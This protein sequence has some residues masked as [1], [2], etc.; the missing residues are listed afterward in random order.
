MA[1]PRSRNLSSL[2]SESG[3]KMTKRNAARQRVRQLLTEQLEPRALLAAGPLLI[4]IQPNNSDLLRAGDVRDVA[5]K[6]LVFRFDDIQRIDPATLAGIRLTSAG[7]DGTFGLLTAESDFGSIGRVSIELTSLVPQQSL[8]LNVT[9]AVL[10]QGAA[11][12]ISVAGNTVSITL[13]TRETSRTTATGLVQAIATSSALAGRMTA[14]IK[15]GLGTVTL[16]HADPTVYS[17]VRVNQTHDQIVQ[18]GAALVGQAPNENEVTLRF[19]E[20]LRDDMYRIEIFGFDDPSIG[21]VGLRNLGDTPSAIGQFYRPSGGS[22]RKDTIDFRLDLGPQVT[23]VVPQP[24]V[25]SGATLQQQRDTIVVYFDSDKMLVENTAAGNPTGR[26]VEHPDFYQ[27]IYTK[28]TVRNTDDLYFKP[29]S[30]TYNALINAVTLKFASDLND[31]PGASS[32][33]AAFRLRIGTRETQPITPTQRTESNV[34]GTFDTALNLATIGSATQSQTSLIVSSAIDPVAF[35]LDLPGASDDPGHRRL[36]QG[37][38]NSM[39]DH[40]NPNFGADSVAGVTTIFYHF[41]S[42]ISNNSGTYFS[43]ITDQQRQRTREVLSLWSSYVGVQF[44]E[45]TNQGL[46]IATGDTAM[47]N[48]IGPFQTFDADLRNEA[49]GLIEAIPYRV[50]LDPTYV[51]PV[52]AMS[53]QIQWNDLYGESFSRAIAAAVGNVLGLTRASDLS[54]SELMRFDPDFFL[55]DDPL[56]DDNDAQL[57]ANDQRFESV[58]PGNQDILHGQFLHRPD[59][60]DVDLYRFEVNFTNP[61]QVGLFAAETYAQRRINSSELDTTI[62]LYREVRAQA[63]TNFNV[64]GLSVEFT[65]KRPGSQGNQFQIAFTQSELGVGVLPIV[66]VFPNAISIALNSTPGSETTVQQMLNAIAASSGANGLVQ[67]RLVEG[68]VTAKIGAN[69]LSQNPVRLR[70]GRFELVAQNND[71]FSRDS[72]MEQSLGTGVY[73]IGV[74]ASGNEDYN[75]SIDGSGFGG[76]TQGAYDL[77]INFRAEVSA[78]NTLQDQAHQPS[79]DTSVGL[80]G[81]ADG[82]T[83]GTH[84]FWFQTRSLNRAITFQVGASAG[85]EGRTV[86]VVGANGTTRVFEFT[87]DSSITPGRYPIQYTASTPATGLAIALSTAING[88]PELGVTATP[89]GTR[90]TLS[91]ERSVTFDPLLASMIQVGGKTIFV[92]K[93]AGPN[94]NGTLANPFNNISGSGVANAFAST[95]PGDIVRI[96]GNSGTDLSQATLGDNFAYEIGRALLPVGS[97][98]PDGISMDIPRGVTTMIDAGALF[99]LRGAVIQAGSSNLS[100]DRSGAVLQ[101]LGTPHVLDSAGNA[102]RTP[103]GDLTSGNVYFTSWLDES[104]GVDSYAPTTSPTPGDWGGLVL[105][106]DLDRSSGRKDL[107]DE[108]IFLRTVNYA[109]IRYGGGTVNVDSVQQVLNPIHI[110]SSRPTV[111]N[112]RVQLSASAAISIDPNAME[113]TNFNEPR[114]QLN[115][116][117]TSDYERVGPT[118][119]GN[120]LVNNSINGVFI[121]IDTPADGS[122]RTMTVPGRMDDTDVVYVLAENLIV[123]GSAGG[124]ILDSTKPDASSI[125]VFATT[126]GTLTAGSY[127]YKLTFVDRNGY[128][129]VASN[130]SSTVTLGANQT[131]VNVSGLTGATGDFVTRRLY[132]SAAGGAGPYTLVAILDRTSPNFVDV[133]QSLGGTLSNSSATQVKRPRLNASLVVDPGIVLKMEAARIEAQMGANIIVEGVDGLPIFMTS[134][135]DNTV[136]AG[137]TFQTSGGGTSTPPRP[138]D[139]GGIYMAP[140]SR[141]SVDYA[142]FSYGGGVTRLEGTFRGFNTIEAHQADVRVAHSEFHNNADGMGGQGPGTRLGRMSNSPATIFVRGAQPIIIENSFQSNAGSVIRIDVNS[143]TDE[144][145]ADAGRQTGLADRNIDYIANRGPLVRDNRLEDNGLNAMEIRGGYLTTGSTWDDTDIVHAVFQPIFTGNIQHSGGLRLLSS[146]TESLVVKFDGYGS[147]FHKNLGAGLTARGELTSANDRVGGTMQI[148]GQPNFPVIL[149]SLKDDS[150]GAGLQPDGSAQ[151]DTNND[152]IG[153]IP[154]SADWRGLLIDQYAN[155]RNVA[156]TLELEDHRALAPGPNGTTLNAQL[157]GELAS[158]PSAGNETLQLGF[159][160]A[161]VLSQPEDVD[162]YSFNGAAGSEVWIDVDYT[163]NYLDMEL[164]LLDANGTL[165]ARSSSSTLESADPSSLVTSGGMPESAV[166]PLNSR[167]AFL[168]TSSGAAK[169]PGTTNVND[170]GMRIRLPGATGLRSTFYIRLRSR[171]QDVNQV[172]SGMSAGA[173]E[174][175]IRLREAQEWAGSTVRFADIRYAMN[176]LHLIGQPGESPLIGEAAE[177]ENVTGTIRDIFGA[178][179]PSSGQFTANNDIATGRAVLERV[180]DPNDP[181]AEPRVRLVGERGNRPQHIGNILNTSKGAISVAGAIGSIADPVDF[182]RLEVRQEDVDGNGYAPVV[183]DVDYADGLNRPD[184]SMNIFAEESSSYG[185]FANIDPLF[186]IPEQNQYR[187]IYSSSGS[188]V[189]DDQPRPLSGADMADFS[190]GSAG[191]RDPFLGPIALPVGNYLVGISSV[192][193]QPRALI[194]AQSTTGIA[195]VNSI[196]RIVDLGYS[197][198]N[199]T[200]DP[201]EVPDFLPETQIGTDGVLESAEFNLGRYSAADLPKLYL[202]Y[203]RISAGMEVFVRR[204]DGSETRII[205]ANELLNGVGQRSLENFAGQNGL[206]LIFRSTNPNTS[207]DNIVIGFA[208]RGEE[209]IG[210]P[211]EPLLAGFNQLVDIDAAGTRIFSLAPYGLDDRPHLSFSYMVDEEDSHQMRV[212]VIANGIAIRVATTEAATPEEQFNELGYQT[213]F[214]LVADNTEHFGLIDMTPWAGQSGLQ[215]VFQ[216]NFGPDGEPGDTPAISSFANVHLVLADGSRVMS[217]EPNSTYAFLGAPSSTVLTGNYQLEVRLGDNFFKSDGFPGSGPTLTQ[218]FDTNDRLAEG[219][220]LLAPNGTQVTDGDTFS[221]SDGINSVVFEFDSDGSVGVGNVPVPFGATQPSYLIAGA[222]R[223]AINSSLVQQ[224][225]QIKAAMSNGVTAATTGRDPRLHIMGNAKLTTLRATVPSGRV[226]VQYTE[227]RSD[228]NVTR[229][230]GQIVVQNNFIRHSRDYGVWS[231]PAPRILDPRDA[232]TPFELQALFLQELPALVGTQAAR[233]LLVSNNSVQGGLLPGIVIQN[234]VLEE[235]GLGGVNI[236]GESPIW[237]ISP[238]SGTTPFNPDQDDPNSGDSDFVPTV[239]SSDPPSHMGFFLDDA[240]VLVIDSDRTRVRF[241]FEDLAGGSAALPVAGSGSVEGNGFALDSSIA[242]YRDTGGDFYQRR[243]GG[244]LQPFATSALETMH[245]LRD[246]ILGSILVTNGTTQV[247]KATVAQSLMGPDPEAP[248]ITGFYPIYYNRAAVYLEGVTHIFYE[249]T[250]AGTSPFEM[251]TLALGQSPQPQTRVIN[252][253][254]VGKDGRASFQGESPLAEAN[255]SIADAVQTWQGTGIKPL[256]YSQSGV[257]GDGG[258]LIAGDALGSSGSSQTALRSTDVDMFQF[259]LGTGERAFINVTTPDS[260]LQAA[261]QIFDSRGVPQAFKNFEGNTVLVTGNEGP[262]GSW[263]GR[264]PTVDFTALK[265]DVYYAAIS[266]VGNITYDPVSLARRSLGSSTGSYQVTI[267]ARRLQEFVITAEDALNYQTGETF[268]I[269]GVPDSDLT[270]STGVTFEFII[271]PGNPSD[272]SHIPINL[273]P[274]WRVPDVARAIAKA[275]NEGDFG[276]PAI[277]NFQELNNGLKGTASPLPAAHAQALGGLAGVLDAPLNDVVGDIG[278]FDD[279]SILETSPLELMGS[280]N[281]LGDNVVSK[282]ELERLLNGPVYQTNQGLRLFPRR[283]DGEARETTRVVNSRGYVATR[284]NYVTLSGLGIGHDRLS[285]VPLSPTS[286]GDGSTEKFVMVKNVAFIDDNGVVLV[287]PDS[288]DENNLNQIIPETGVLS[289]R[290]ASPTLLNNVFFNV[291]T[292]VVNEESRRFPITLTPAP[293][294]TNNPSNPV[295]PGQVILGGSMYQFHETAGSITRFATGIEASPTNIPNTALDFNQIVPATT[296]LFVNAQ[297]GNYLPAPNSPLIDSS[298]DSLPERSGLATVKTSMG[299]SVSP[300][301][302]PTYDVVGQLRTDDPNVSPPQGQ[303]FSVFKDRGAYDRADFVGPAALLLRPVDNDSLGV[304]LDPSDSVVQLV[305]GVYPEFRILLK[306][307]NE[308]ANPLFGLGINDSTVTGEVIPDLRALGAALVI[309]EN[310]RML[311]EGVDYRF[312]YNATRD[313]IVLTP[314]AGIWQDGNVYEITLNNRNRFV[315]TAPAG[316][317]VADGSTFS[318]IDENGAAVQ[319]EFDSGYRLQVPRSLTM[320]VPEAGSAFG[321]ITDGNRFVI[322]A[323]NGTTTTFEFDTNGNSLAGNR[324]VTV[325]NGASQQVVVGAIIA[326]INAAQIGLVA[327]DLGSGEIAIGAESGVR[328][329]TGDAI[330]IDLPRETLAFSVPDNIARGILRDGHQFSLSDGRRARTFEFDDDGVVTEGSLGINFTGATSALDVMQLIQ[331]SIQSSGL[332]LT[333]SIL[334]DNLLYIGLPVDGIVEA[335]NSP[336]NVV[337][338]SRTVRDGQTFTISNGG[339][340]RRFEFDLNG[341]VASGNIAI[342]FTATTSQNELADRIVTAIQGAGLQLQPRRIGNG[343]VSIGGTETTLIDVAGA[344]TIGLFG[345]PGIQSNTQLQLSGPLL[346]KMPVAGVVEN[347]TFSVTN[348]GRTVTFEF[349]SNF[350]GPSQPGN[351]IVRYEVANPPAIVAQLVAQA[352]VGANLGITPVVQAGGVLNFGR[353]PD[354]TFNVQSSGLTTSRGLV[355]DGEIFTISFGSQSVTFEFDDTSLGNGVAGGN[356]PIQFSPTSTELSV[357]ETMRAVINSSGLSLVTTLESNVLSLNDTSFHSIV[358][359]QAPTIVRTGIPGGTHRV[360]FIPDASFTSE[361]MKRAIIAAINATQGSTISAN[362]RGGNTFWLTGAILVSDDLDNY[363]VQGIADNAGN[364]LKP[365]QIDGETRF[366]ILMPNVELNFGDAPDPFG[367]SQGRYPT[368]FA[369]DG[370]RH[371]ITDFARLGTDMFA[372]T[373]GRPGATASTDLSDDGVVFGTNYQVAGL[374]NKNIQTPITVTLSSPGFVD[375]WID[376]NIDGDWSDPFEQVFSSEAF[377][378]DQLTRTFLVSVPASAAVPSSMTSTFARFRSSTRGQLTPIGIAVDGEVEDYQVFIAPGSPPVAANDNYTIVEDGLLTTTDASGQT[379][380]GFRA[381]DGVA[382]NDTKTSSSPMGVVLVQGPAHAKSFELRSDGT[383]TY[384]PADNFWGTDTFT[385]RVNDGLL[386]SNN[387]GTVSIAVSEVNDAPVAVND[388]FNSDENVPLTINASALLANDSRGPNEAN[389]SITVTRVD[390]ASSRGGTVSLVAGVITYTPAPSFSGT[391][392]FTYSI[393]DN[394]TTAGVPAPLSATGTVTIIVTEVND[395]PVVSPYSGRMQ[396]NRPSAPSSLSL[397]ESVL[398][399]L[400]V[401]GPIDERAWQSVRLIGVSSTSAN[402]GSVAWNST[403]GVITFIPQTHFSGVDRFTF[404]IEDFSTDPQRPLVSRQATG[405]A[406]INV[407][408]VN[409]PP[410]VAVPLG[411]VTMLEDEANR[412]I[413][414]NAFFTDPDIAIAGDSLTYSIVSNSVTTLV[415]PTI[416][417]RNLTLALAAD[418]NGQSVIVVQAQDEGGSTTR[419]TLTLTVTPVNDAPRLGAP[420]P[421]QNVNKNATIPGIVLSPTYFFDPDTAAGGDSLTF[422]VTSN[423]NPLLV[424]PTII[425]GVLQLTLLPNQFGSAIV[426]ISATDSSGLSVSST[427][428]LNVNNVNVPPE[429]QSDSYRVAQRETLSVTADNGVLANDSDPEGAALTAILVTGPQHAAQFNLNASGSFTYRHD[430]QSRATDTFTYRASDG[431]GN[432][433]VITVTITIDPP[434]PST[435]QNPDRNLDV[436][437]DGRISPIDALLIINLLNSRTGTILVNT[438]PPPPAYYDVNGD[439]RI[440]PVDALQVINELNSQSSGGGGEG[441]GESAPLVDSHPSSINTF[442]VVH[443]TLDRAYSLQEIP[444]AELLSTNQATLRKSSSSNPESSS[445][446]DLDWVD[447]LSSRKRRDEVATDS[448]MA[449]LMLAPSPLRSAK[450]D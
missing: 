335:D 246:S 185:L 324:A 234:N 345:D 294:G 319:Y 148:I 180:D 351:V 384:D 209:I 157:L 44:I 24:V 253:T 110:L 161:G 438:L 444:E 320:L 3:F 268:T 223:D 298:I 415:T 326:A 378:P 158:K 178:S 279:F 375:G 53:T 410:E 365:N 249:N 128:E 284:T 18:P 240:D 381:D 86:T 48:P 359:S 38:P 203:T 331:A 305:D 136:G 174:V 89:S 339:P 15:G 262:N 271:G 366:T 70:D 334:A 276:D 34:G 426:T 404:V 187:L 172:G 367:G 255:D 431:Q 191:G 28:D 65:S 220:S 69:T 114:F 439:Y 10:A 230:Q 108:G 361:D 164:E 8:T 204:S 90:V 406:F 315:I 167:D 104:K 83:G 336:L 84:D 63:E 362:D 92:D 23:A 387:I 91:N 111:T 354:S 364:L 356:T 237:M 156:L 269:H 291:Q 126:G 266:S 192:A 446:T 109:D 260:D 397:N 292:P 143:M 154:Q 64:D 327:I 224:R 125:I 398:E 225:L 80:D 448:A 380:P 206:R 160:V 436:N 233:N 12:T 179:L 391:D 144:L 30:V 96:V 449:D 73:Y 117:F 328:L 11:P 139:W 226:Q 254:I 16:G 134:R 379:T 360:S 405:T 77:R 231:E 95:H 188:N 166:N 119:R 385:Y 388:S 171:G 13:N 341:S 342:P 347:S 304:D 377:G 131:A 411:T 52:I 2:R 423:T 149:T 133:G 333:P 1:I 31:L 20:T 329:D 285:T 151:T 442:D 293:Y 348:A 37:T 146:P 419:G 429:G 106:R 198:G 215:V 132:R 35:E 210:V 212:Y 418:R 382:A 287:S 409:D 413:D 22:T 244:S 199:T 169:E 138:R 368:R 243:T 286:V 26:S 227:G 272:P 390:A 82:H 201:P 323:A 159:I 395:P 343:N 441:E 340:S 173:Y 258:P 235:G 236:S 408:N 306:D 401:P 430:G 392:T 337:G 325:P 115:G 140:T 145:V 36:L 147:N 394:G 9:H 216:T 175:Q 66:Q 288:N 184:L 374:F 42:S 245:A 346:V 393:T 321:G 130:P 5:P 353:V 407:L 314:L 79:R 202:E 290:G 447:E 312:S 229:E 135:F 242:W 300:V 99:K 55:V 424:T 221:I 373:D 177:D 445:H 98:L 107:E 282:R 123:E 45:T 41:P 208:E 181:T 228:R 67:A 40:I 219:T 267:D 280:L 137:G 205:S 87:S 427:L 350:S 322:T 251:R 355:A 265:P 49:T 297:A 238:G 414:L 370:A 252:N 56:I 301:L 141:L 100:I 277:S 250:I 303:G 57:N 176:G 39:D 197:G 61:D 43:A 263:I 17:P 62:Q 232:F 155:D 318:F 386:N 25:R 32:S 97:A 247:V 338:A 218:S 403:T 296:Q 416:S 399:A 352:I 425:N 152:G 78:S 105:R 81:D 450:T 200:A 434:L 369:N 186:R 363:F 193:Y 358:T 417:G 396:E 59:S 248:T 124:S 310:G 421:T 58:F 330:S 153:S 196:R 121:G 129:S 313:E 60:T 307:G 273:G 281:E 207:I 127:N 295:K 190:R 47:I 195:P 435:H 428:T 317:Q 275:I 311:V 103:D 412:T 261:L 165:L 213:E 316:D 194:T 93:T 283:A 142:R 85:L 257:I 239:N 101:V 211:D 256:E 433:D 27:L 120:W 33:G 68:D 443:S 371:V 278:G 308:P 46:A 440:S 400:A 19:A 118:F 163:K 299:L 6:E 259:K 422:A 94:A 112:N 162:V 51:N 214:P 116:K 7:G 74:S 170:P 270:N 168:Q 4:G 29:Q 432:S 357:L 383:F 309:T 344:P 54:K 182:Y 372:S 72:Y 222:I 349:D 71:Y 76:R 113:E 14:R 102:L 88:R 402:G 21:V 289:T 389:Q 241:E 420:L 150:V 183:F 302:A 332:N 274:E 264:D 50:Q 217:G 376:W 122:L 75:A 437:A 189:A